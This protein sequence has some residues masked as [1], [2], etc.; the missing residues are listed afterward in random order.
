MNIEITRITQTLATA[1]AALALTWVMSWGFVD[2]TRVVRT[3]D[4][5][6]AMMIAAASEAGSHLV[7]AGGKALLK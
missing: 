2:A 7:Q 3:M 6:E 1:T 5:A 4:R